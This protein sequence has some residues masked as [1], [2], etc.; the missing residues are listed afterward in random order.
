LY[1]IRTGFCVTRI[2]YNSRETVK[3]QE[4]SFPRDQVAK[5]RRN[6]E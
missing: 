2:I 6:N 3:S 5:P 1:R 4:P